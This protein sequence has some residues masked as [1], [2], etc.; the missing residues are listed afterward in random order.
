MSIRV[1]DLEVT[2][3]QGE[4]TVRALR[5]VDLDVEPGEVVAIVGRSGAG[6]STLLRVLAGIVQPSA[7]SAEVAGHPMGVRS[8]TGRIAHRDIGIMFQ[9]HGLVPQLSALENA[10]CGRL[11]EYAGHAPV[12]RWRTEHVKDVRR[13]LADLGLGEREGARASKLSGGER[14]RVAVARLLHQAPT[15][16][17]VDEPVASLDVHWAR[18]SIRSV[19]GIRGGNVTIVAVL[20]DLELVRTWATRAVLMEDGVIT[21]TGDPEEACR[22]LEASGGVDEPEPPG[23]SEGEERALSTK[24]PAPDDQPGWSRRAWYGVFG[25]AA[26]AAYVWALTGVDVELEDLLGSGSAA[27]DFLTRALPPDFSA[28]PTLWDSLVETVQ[29]ALLGTTFAAFVA[30][31]LAV[32]GASNIAPRPVVVASRMVL[33]LM[34]TIPSIIWGLFFVILVGLGPFPGI[35]ALTFYAAG[36]LGKFF[37]E[38]IEAIDPTPARA[39]KTVGASRLQRFRWA[40]WPQVFPVLLGHT[41]YMFEYNVRAASILGLVGAGGIGFWLNMYVNNFKYQKAATAILLL[42]VVVTVIDAVST[43]LRHRVMNG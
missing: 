22:L 38:G 17:L 37:Y 1:R 28:V 30:L 5:G 6:K 36:Y 11:F 43:R 7:G 20:H 24:S 40:V 41:L 18:E 19:A 3:R 13:Y 35:L 8:A 25:L 29:M 14:Q 31:P 26:I 34:R 39:L 23:P 12:A 27:A 9:D 10:L 21:F 4:R 2:Y 15:V 16:A 32:A 33:N 42:L